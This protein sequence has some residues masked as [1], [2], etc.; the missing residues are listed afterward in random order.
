MCSLFTAYI[1]TF[2]LETQYSSSRDGPGRPSYLLIDDRA[3]PSTPTGFDNH[4][5]ATDLSKLP[6][7]SY[8]F[9][10]IYSTKSH[11]TGSEINLFDLG[12]PFGGLGLYYRSIL[13]IS[14]SCPWSP[15]P[16]EPIGTTRT[17]THI[18][19]L[20]ILIPANESPG[21]LLDQGWNRHESTFW[22]KG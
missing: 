10:S 9:F 22:W 21:Q 18:L 1:V 11:L 4:R 17:W 2:P 7:L 6:Y 16:V 12:L 5:N 15:T 8:L 20:P 19:W 13:H 14:A 3:W